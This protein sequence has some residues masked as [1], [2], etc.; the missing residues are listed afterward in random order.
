MTAIRVRKSHFQGSGKVF[1]REPGNLAEI[2][3]GLAI[4][5]ARSKLASTVVAD[6]TDNT[7]GVSAGEV[8]D[9]VL[10][11]APFNAVSAGGATRTAFNTAIGKFKNASSSMAAHLNR[12]RARLGLEPM[13]WA[14]GTVTAGTLPAQDKSVATTNGATSLNYES[15][16]TAM[17]KAKQNMRK[18]VRGFNEVMVAVGIPPIESALSG[19]AGGSGYDLVAI[20]DAAAD[21]DSPAG[22]TAISKAVIDT[23]LDSA[24]DNFASLAAYWNMAMVQAGL[25][26]LTDNSGGTGAGETMAALGH[27][28]TAHQDVA[29]NSSPVADFNTELPKIENNFADLALRINT[30]GLLHGLGPLLVDSTGGTAN[31][32]LEVIDDT[33]TAVDG[34]TDSTLSKASADVTFGEMADNFA[35]LV[36]AVNVLCEV[37]GVLPLVDAGDGEADADGELIALTDGV[38]VDNGAEATGTADADID[39]ALDVVTDNLATVA[40]KLN[41][42]TGSGLELEAHPLHVVA[43]E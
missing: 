9:L 1:G 17:L 27:P 42:M 22:S 38:G 23:F 13:S 29:T 31:T 39:A 4:D 32:T 35:T 36:V 37:H 8:V 40:A 2:V 10:P 15:G 5:N 19:E 14:T 20:A 16:R 3:R 12:V 7:T 6:F 11:T 21:T 28:F 33:L 24:A 34:S 43:V 30:L 41:A 25:S 26:D 18:L